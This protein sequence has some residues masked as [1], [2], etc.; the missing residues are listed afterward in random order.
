M[1][2]MWND[3]QLWEKKISFLISRYFASIKVPGREL[4]R[5]G[6]ITSVTERLRA[7]RGGV[8]SPP[9]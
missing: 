5:E 8:T 9:I 3:V 2:L 6:V 7:R 1:I 4:C